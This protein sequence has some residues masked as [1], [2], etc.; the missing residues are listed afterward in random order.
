MLSMIFDLRHL[1]GVVHDLIGELRLSD[2]LSELLDPRTSR[3]GWAVLVNHLV[4]LPLGSVAVGED[5]TELLD[6]LKLPT[7]KG[8]LLCVHFVPVH[9]EQVKVHSRNCL[10]QA[11]KGGGNL[12]LLEDT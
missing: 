8:V 1:G 2:V 4:A 5:A 11:L 10:N 9:L 7:E 3:L 12:E 6:H